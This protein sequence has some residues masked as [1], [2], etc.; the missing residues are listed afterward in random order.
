MPHRN[1][2]KGGLEG[3]V[4]AKDGVGG[5]SGLTRGLYQS[6][7]KVP[8]D[9]RWFSESSVSKEE[10]HRQSLDIVLIASAKKP[11]IDTP[12]GDLASS[13]RNHSSDTI[14]LSEMNRDAP[15]TTQRDVQSIDPKRKR[16]NTE[17]DGEKI[18]PARKAKN[19]GPKHPQSSPTA[20]MN[21]DYLDG[22]TESLRSKE[23]NGNS[24]NDLPSTKDSTAAA[25]KKDDSKKVDSQRRRRSR[26][27]A[28]P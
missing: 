3:F 10:M 17:E 14:P 11:T 25:V 21:E 5:D 15:R 4:D 1:I 12:G 27:G 20:K 8:G 22:H 18:P 7:R 6:I 2:C 16:N 9:V 23:D 19:V 28:K 13:V 26:R 24:T